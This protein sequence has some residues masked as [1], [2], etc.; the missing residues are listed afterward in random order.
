[1]PTQAPVTGF[2][3]TSST[4]YSAARSASRCRRLAGVADHPGLGRWRRPG[5]RC[6]SSSSRFSASSTS[7]CGTSGWPVRSA[8]IMWSC[9]SASRRASSAGLGHRHVHGEEGAGLVQ[10]GR[11]AERGAVEL[12][13]LGRAAAR[14]VVR[15]H[16]RHALLG[17][18]PG[19]VVRG[20]EQPD[21]GHRPGHRG[22]PQRVGAAGH[23]EPDAA[24]LHHR[25]HV[26]DV[27][28]EPADGVV[29]DAAGPVAQRERRH[30][31][32][33]GSA[34]EAE[35]DPARVGGLQERE[36]LGHHQRRVVR[37]HDAAAA[38][39]DPLG[40]AGHHRHQHRRVGGGDGRHVV[41]L[42]QPVPA[43]AEGVRG[44]R[45]VEGRGQGVARGLVGAHRHEVEHR[46]GR[47]VGHQGRNARR[48]AGIPRARA[49]SHPEAAPAP[50]RRH[51]HPPGLRDTP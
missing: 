10:L 48:R 30:R 51:W 5:S 3:I 8:S 16:V 36:L 2:T 27:L 11:G 9:G 20:A 31:V 13:R 6:P 22:G 38:D 29:G 15:E 43:V 23:R 44:A 7:G 50:P 19:R 17:R 35:V 24:R 25:E 14:E 46:E 39:P 33:A 34:A 1:M 18:E 26:L 42:G 4:P 40:G 12:Q 47:Q 37:Q 28:G 45:E 32:G 49:C 41:V 21:L